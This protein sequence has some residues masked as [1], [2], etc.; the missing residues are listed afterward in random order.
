MKII[1]SLKLALFSLICGL[2]ALI[3]EHFTGL[4]V[5]GIIA[6]CFAFILIASIFAF[7]VSLIRRFIGNSVFI[8]LTFFFLFA[9]LAL[10]ASNYVIAW[11]YF[12]FAS[13]ISLVLSSCSI[14]A[15]IGKCFFK[16]DKT[17]NNQD[18]SANY[19]TNISDN[20]YPKN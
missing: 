13:K 1:Q 16:K 19:T 3:A 20:Q 8:N 7:L 18:T 17:N 9:A 6:I 10:Y 15:F 5:A 4:G 14:I 12:I 11:N 2:I